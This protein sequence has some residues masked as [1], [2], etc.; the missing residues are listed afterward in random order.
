MAVLFPISM[1]LL[2]IVEILHGGSGATSIDVVVIKDL[3]VP[4]FDESWLAHSC[5][6]YGC[7][8]DQEL[9]VLTS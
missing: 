1:L 4:K 8:F 3:G 5:L 7:V 2:L 6:R 9:S